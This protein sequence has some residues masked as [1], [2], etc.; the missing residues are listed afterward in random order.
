[1]SLSSLIQYLADFVAYSW[2][3]HQCGNDNVAND[4]PA[5]CTSCA[6]FHCW[7]CENIIH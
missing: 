1:M 4:H 6:H 2:N 7:K 5:Q 3:C